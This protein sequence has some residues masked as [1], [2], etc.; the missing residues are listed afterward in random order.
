VRPTEEQINEAQTRA[1]HRA[2]EVFVESLR[3]ELDKLGCTTIIGALGRSEHVHY[4]FFTGEDKGICKYTFVFD[5]S[6]FAISA[7][8]ASLKKRTPGR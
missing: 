4:C 3:E 5:D 1:A 8:L 6:P 2:I 7:A